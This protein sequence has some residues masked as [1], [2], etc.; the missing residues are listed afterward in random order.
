M[1]NIFMDQNSKLILVNYS[2]KIKKFN[3][4]R[5]LHI[6]QHRLLILKIELDFSKLTLVSLAMGQVKKYKIC[7]KYFLGHAKKC[8]FCKRSQSELA[9]Q[10]LL[11]LRAFCQLPLYFCTIVL[12]FWA[13]RKSAVFA[14]SAFGPGE[15]NKMHQVLLGHAKN[16]IFAQFHNTNLHIK[17][18]WI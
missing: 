1:P 18:C 8:S 11:D 3:S 6:F 17:I 16:A 12:V 15:E 7:T 10:N 13:S 2:I 14:L 4:K 9:H 5:Y